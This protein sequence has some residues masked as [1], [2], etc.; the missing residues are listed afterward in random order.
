MNK[1]IIDAQLKLDKIKRIEVSLLKDM[2]ILF[3][4]LSKKEI[5]KEE[6][7]DILMVARQEREKLHS[8][9]ELN[10]Y[11]GSKLV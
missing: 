8:D 7:Q 9:P 5:L 3:S 1:Q 4:F 2:N 6:I 11:Y 10:E